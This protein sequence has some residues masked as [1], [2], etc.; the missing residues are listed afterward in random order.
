[1]I[2]LQKAKAGKE[3][4]LQVTTLS[5]LI[6]IWI[7]FLALAILSPT[8]LAKASSENVTKLA[9][10]KMTAVDR[11]HLVIGNGAR[12]LADRLDRFFSDEQ[13]EEELQTTRVRL[14]PTIQWSEADN[15]DALIPFRIDLV[16]PRLKNKWKVLLSSFRDKDDDQIPDDADYI[17]NDGEDEDDDTG[18]F[19]G[20]QY[21][22]LSGIARH[23][24][25]SAGPKFKGKSVRFFA[26]ARVRFQYRIG[27][28]TA[29]LSEK[30]FYDKEFGERTTFD[31]QRPIGTKEVFRSLSAIT[32]SETSK[33]VDL[34]QVFLLRHFFSETIAAGISGEIAAHTRPST[35]VDAYVLAF[36]Y[37]Q[38]IWRDWLYLDV[39]PQARFPREVD[40]EFTPFLGLSLE[41][42]F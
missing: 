40:F 30:V 9:F 32:C 36:E 22:A 41:A 12:S 38:K 15:L 26:S 42:I 33:G 18:I 35:V 1:M 28:W 23:I 6:N 27:P 5:K 21:T 24:K 4:I 20:L 14:K 31:F 34:R 39:N 16:L 29:N 37:R 10:Q 2:F 17:D 7:L 13:I 19:L 8:A 3:I 25:T 11:L